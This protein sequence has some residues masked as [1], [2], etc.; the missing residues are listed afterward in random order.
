MA[1]DVVAEGIDR[2]ALRDV[3]IYHDVFCT[4]DYIALKLR[5]RKEPVCRICACV[6]GADGLHYAVISLNSA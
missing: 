4:C 5:R 3:V 2:A 1:F 6:I